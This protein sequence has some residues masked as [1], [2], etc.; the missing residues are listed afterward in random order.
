MA[1]PPT[2]AA[3]RKPESAAQI[4]VEVI[5]CASRSLVDSTRLCLPAGSS[6]D[7]ALDAAGIR[8]R[9]A[10]ID[11]QGCRVGIWGRAVA[12]QQIVRDG[13]RVE[14]YRPLLV[15]PKQARRLRQR[16]Q[17]EQRLSKKP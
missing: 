10:E 13:D 6:V 2:D 9:R 14:V 1:E 5:F 4:E 16:H 8:Q 3:S 7:D 17:A 11:W 12:L 15:E